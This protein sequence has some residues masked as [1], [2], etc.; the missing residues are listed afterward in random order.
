MLIRFSLRA[1]FAVVALVSAGFFSANFASAQTK[2]QRYAAANQL[3]AEALHREVYGD[4][5]D[6][7][8]LLHEAIA[9]D[10]SLPEANWH[11]GRVK[12]RGKWVDFQDA[13]D[14]A[15]TNPRLQ[16]YRRLREEAEQTV[17]GQMALAD[18]C[19]EHDLHEQ[20]EAHLWAII[21]LSPNHVTARR[22]LGHIRV[23]GMWTTPQERRDQFEE[24]VSQRKSLG[25]W[26]PQM[27]EI[28][29]NLSRRGKKQRDAAEL[30]LRA[31]NTP[32]AITA[33]ETEICPLGVEASQLVA[34]VI[35]NM[36]KHEAALAL[37]RHAV[38][39]PHASVRKYACEQLAG[40]EL[41]DY[42]PALL[43]ELQTPVVT[44]SQIYR[45]R[46]GSLVCRQVM[47][48]EGQDHRDLAVLETEYQRIAR[49]GGN[50]DETLA[51]AVA[52]LQRTSLAREAAIRQENTQ[53][54]AMNVRV[55]QV[56]E[57]S[58]GEILPPTP[59]EWWDWWNEE[60]EVFVETDKQ[61]RQVY[62]RDEVALVDRPV[63][64][65]TS[66]G[67]TDDPQPTSGT[68]VFTGTPIT[69]MCDCLAA[70]T[71]VWTDVGP[72]AI[73]KIQVGDRV[74]SQNP[75]TGELAYQPVLGT[76]IRPAGEL[77]R[78]DAG[79]DAITTS[80]GHLYWIAGEGWT[81]A[82]DV[83]SGTELHTVRGTVRV[84]KVGKAEFA[85]TYNWIVKDFHTYFVG[86]SLALCHDNT[87]S[88]PTNALV[89]GLEDY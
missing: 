51:R 61:I 83:K 63:F 74:L 67:P 14:E 20:E 50:R 5:E 31:V 77:I 30:K 41:H 44:R 43:A 86:S 33:M 19:R 11:L 80:G 48:R 17:A 34:E 54:M 85:P 36:D 10:P 39:S 66:P 87:I 88:Q 25:E 68:P 64:Q 53:T 35:A 28:A 70:G 52:D 45:G 75:D 47:A 58:T 29:Q 23:D 40:R 24:L 73:E 3:V 69:G 84:S 72:M 4:A 65:E 12:Q 18:W 38:L 6:R 81:K 57:A 26:Q 1:H 22:R 2:A 27:R 79:Q 9:H 60:N 49:V 55:M 8:E 46:G 42:V 59:Q 82:R 7:N 37:A 13:A 71:K 62:Q 15:K 16:E 89:P 32:L 56:L 76:T 78:I 21:E